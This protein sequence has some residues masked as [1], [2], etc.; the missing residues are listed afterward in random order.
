MSEHWTINS[1]DKKLEFFKYV[2]EMFDHHKYITFDA[3]R[4]GADRSIPQNGL[5]QMWAREYAAYLMKIPCKEVAK[6]QHEGIK[7]KLKELFYKETAE[8]WMVMDTED[9]ITGDRKKKWASSADW[10]KPEAFMFLTWFQALA[11][12]SGLILEAKGE[13]AKLKREQNE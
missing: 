3:P 8:S 13:Y 4:I 6:G 7:A 11:H 5:L 1:L 2:G 12:D 9:P 10:K